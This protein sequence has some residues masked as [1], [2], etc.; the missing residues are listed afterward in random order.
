MREGVQTEEYK[1][2]RLTAAPM[3]MPNGRW[4]V[5]VK[6]S[7]QDSSPV[8]EKSYFAD[9]KIYYILKEE[10]GKEAINLGRN[11]INRMM[12]GI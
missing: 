3:K 1:D 12:S 5:S 10:A 2:Y 4:A 11:I 7:R 8:L 9:D 6:I